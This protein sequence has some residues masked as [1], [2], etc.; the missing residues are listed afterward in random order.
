[1]FGLIS[2]MLKAARSCLAAAASP[3]GIDLGSDMLRLLQLRDDEAGPSIVAVAQRDVPPYAADNMASYA[4]FVGEA[5][6]EL[7]REAGFVGRR[8][9]LGLPGDRQHWLHLRLPK[10]D[11]N[12]LGETL[13]FECA[14]KLPFDPQGAVL[15]H[16]VIGDVYTKDGPRQEVLCTAARRSDVEAL[17]SAAESA[18]LEIVGIGATAAALRDGFM[19]GYQREG[20]DTTGFCFVDIGRRSTR[21]TVVRGGHL[22]FARS[23]PIGGDHFSEAVAK[24]LSVPMEEAKLLRCRLADAEHQSAAKATE[25]KAEE[26]MVE[27][28]VGD[29]DH[30]FALLGA[31]MRAS[32]VRQAAAVPVLATGASGTTL[33][34]NS[35]SARRVWEATRPIADELTD[36]LARC[37]RYHES[38]FTNV[39]IERLVFV[40]G[41]ANQRSL[42]R[43]LA[44]RLGIAAQ[45]GDLLTRLSLTADD[46]THGR[47]LQAGVD[48]QRPLPAW[49]LACGLALGA[50][51]HATKHHDLQAA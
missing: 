29:G 17:L 51:K 40:G 16:H 3:V 26:R 7:W 50:S 12:Q 18:R 45:V 19:R 21:V 25:F 27:P 44:Q 9:I 31:A 22:Y 10:L 5:L 38:T 30:S 41:E 39:L 34:I 4:Q 14:G 13:K 35:E 36:E 11:A 15:R 2:P 23:V 1:M 37:R 43:H 20:D 8:A 6:R 28:V 24:A 32:E 47:L 48:L 33:D 46:A 42:C 49:S